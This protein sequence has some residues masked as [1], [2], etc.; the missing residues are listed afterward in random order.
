MDKLHWKIHCKYN[1]I[2]LQKSHS[3]HTG[4]TLCFRKINIKYIRVGILGAGVPV[5]DCIQIQYFK[6]TEIGD[7]LYGVIKGLPIS[8]SHVCSILRL[9]IYLTETIAE[10]LNSWNLERI[11]VNYICKSTLA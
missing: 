3:N 6:Y 9:N 10:V 11:P 1:Q 8:I 2:T 4:I 7:S 5:Y